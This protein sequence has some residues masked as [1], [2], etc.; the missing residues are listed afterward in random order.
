MSSALEKEK[1][2]HWLAFGTALGAFRENRFIPH[3]LDI[4]IATTDKNAISFLEREFE[5]IV[6]RVGENILTLTRDNISLDLY[7]F[8]KKEDK[9]S[10]YCS[11]G[12]EYTLLEK[13]VEG[14]FEQISFC[15]KSF[16]L[17]NN[18]QSYFTRVYGDDWQIPIKGKHAKQ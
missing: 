3:D 12:I 14:G 1:I 9:D 10:C 11:N 5:D 16:S 8:E 4:D 7:T 6:T 17:V 13:E 18:P 2:E 15:D